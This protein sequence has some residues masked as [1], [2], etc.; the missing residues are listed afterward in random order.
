MFKDHFIKHILI[1]FF[2]V[3]I[4][5]KYWHF[6]ILSLIKNLRYD[7]IFLKTS[8]SINFKFGIEIFIKCTKLF[9]Y[10]LWLPI[11]LKIPMFDYDNL[12]KILSIH[13]LSSSFISDLITTT[14]M[15]GPIKIWIL[16]STTL[17]LF[18]QNVSCLKILM[19]SPRFGQSHVS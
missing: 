19:Y 6:S 12:R 2:K 13:H 8:N 4:L 5:I 15:F 7:W 10:G 18:I 3:P 9:V 11:F 16:L 14:N 17:L 1:C